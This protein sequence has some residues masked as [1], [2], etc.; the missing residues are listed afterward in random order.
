MIRLWLCILGKSTTEVICPLQCINQ[1]LR[2][3]V[4]SWRSNSKFDHLIKVVF[5][6][7][8]YCQ[9]IIF[10]FVINQHL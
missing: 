8:L 3:T 2:D 10:L 5:S 4:L 9:V 6:E 7:F 1:V